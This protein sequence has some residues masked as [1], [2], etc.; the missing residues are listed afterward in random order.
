MVVRELLQ[1]LGVLQLSFQHILL[2]ALAHAVTCL[3]RLLYLAQQLVTPLQN[4]EGLLNVGQVEIDHL[5]ISHY[6]SA[7]RIGLRFHRVRFVFGN[8][9]AQLPFARVRDVLRRAEPDVREV[10]I[11]VTRERAWAADAELLH[12]ELRLRKSRGL[13]GNIS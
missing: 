3:G 4:P 5:E 2:V 8:T 13:P 10:A 11:A 12:R 9:G 7:D 1:N 6:R